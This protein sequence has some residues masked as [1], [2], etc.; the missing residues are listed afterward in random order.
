MRH[1]VL[2]EVLYLVVW[3]AVNEMR[4][5]GWVQLEPRLYRIEDSHR[6][7]EAAVA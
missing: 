2:T 1:S 7:H 4:E 6:C 5:I 3:D